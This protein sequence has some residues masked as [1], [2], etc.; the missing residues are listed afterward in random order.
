M[1]SIN[2]S[3]VG[4]F[5]T[6]TNVLGRMQ[7]AF[8]LFTAFGNIVGD[9]SIISG[10]VVSGSNTSNGVVFI[11]NEPFEFIGGLTQPKVIIKEETETLLFQNNNS[12]P[13]IKTRYITFGSGVE[14]MD[15]ADFKQG[16]PTKNIQGLI[17][18]IQ[19]LEA[20]PLVGNIPIGLIALWG[21]PANEIP[22]GW[23]EITE[24]AGKMPVG[25]DEKDSDYDV[26]GKA[27]G[28]K[29]KTLS[30]P[31]LPEHAHDGHLVQA[32]SN[33]RGGGNNSGD[34][35]TSKYGKSSPVGG[36]KSFSIMN[37]YRVVHY[38]KYVG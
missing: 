6:T 10:C 28:S 5:P 34:D 9:K 35:A 4:G 37:P 3:Q 29:T 16:F 31:E 24:M 13:V 12:Y 32:S 7:T 19:K 14:A 20:R 11:N 27:G 21:R 2:F 25:F 23:Q 15:W 17:D 18:R 22:A 33:W 38:I 36:G 26:V 1:N 30:I 8:N